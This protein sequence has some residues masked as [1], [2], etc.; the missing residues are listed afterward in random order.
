MNPSY[1]DFLISDIDYVLCYNK[2]I[3]RMEQV[4]IYIWKKEQKFELCL[5]VFGDEVIEQWIAKHDRR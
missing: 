4:E 2:H 5:E 3:K 1:V